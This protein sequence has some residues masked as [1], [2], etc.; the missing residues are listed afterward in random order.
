[1][2]PVVSIVIPVKNEG[3][4]IRVTLDA[5][6]ATCGDLAYEIIVVD[7][8]STDGCCDA[9]AQEWAGSVA[10]A[11]LRT[12]GIGAAAAR[13]LGAAHARGT[14]LVFCDGNVIPRA[15]WL[16]GLLHDLD[17]P[18]VDLVAPAVAVADDL[19]RR[20]CGLTFDDRLMTHWLSPPTAAGL[21]AVPVLATTCLALRTQTF[22]DLDGFDGLF[23]VLGHED[24][25]FSL[26]AWLLGRE[27]RVDPQLTVEHV[28]RTER[29]YPLDPAVFMHNVVRMAYLHLGPERRRRLVERLG[30][31]QVVYAALA[32]AE[33]TA[34]N[35]RA[36]Y[37]ARRVHDDDWYVARFNLPW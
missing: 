35:L 20:G 21:A 6:R 32:A 5:I 27:L 25:E 30:P 3:H 24:A 4:H 31:R 13:N 18:G 12:P 28:F 23:R 16:P 22:Q 17:Q 34:A 36:Y 10:F 8:G 26:R 7:D 33:S 15:G 9:L 11:L 2:A 37:Q 1:M 29:P 19:S 14:T